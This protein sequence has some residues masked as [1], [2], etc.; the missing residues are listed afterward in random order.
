MIIHMN[1]KI[2]PGSEKGEND[3]IPDNNKAIFS[4]NIIFT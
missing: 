1:G 3:G 2:L 4:G